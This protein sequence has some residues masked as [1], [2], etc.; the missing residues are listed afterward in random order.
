MTWGGVAIAG[1]SLVA[2]NQQAQ[3]Q[4]RATNSAEELQREQT[5]KAQQYLAPYQQFGEEQ[6][7]G[8]KN[9]LA[10]PE[11][12]GGAQF[13]A[14]TQEDVTSGAGY[15]SR[16][17]A[18]ENSAAA[19]GGLFSGNALRDIGD[20]GSREYDKQYGRNLQEYQIGQNR[21]QNE[22][23]KRLGLVN[24][25]YGAAGGSSGLAQNLG[26]ALSPLAMS[27]GQIE[28]DAWGDRASTIGSAYGQYQGQ[29]NWNA[30]L[31]KFGSKK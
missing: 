20:F 22:L 24:I 12:Q 11:G 29:K 23:N 9:W 19:R 8:F 30:F 21:Y 16:L 4:K 31:D 15:Q 5:A 7:G 1:A 18:I 13:T 3:A 26:Q 14:P 2:G 27:K 10:S 25:G 28:G 17:G 6:L